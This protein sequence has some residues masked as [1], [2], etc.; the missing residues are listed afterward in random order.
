M[1]VGEF[2]KAAIFDLKDMNESALV[3]EL[4]FDELELD[5]LDYVE[6]KL[7]IKKQFKVELDSGLFTSGELTKL[8][9][10]I[11]YIEKNKVEKNEV[12]L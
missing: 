11:S 7:L 2:L 4:T 8:G 9:D 12:Q 3:P 1:D 6:L 5:S 10:L